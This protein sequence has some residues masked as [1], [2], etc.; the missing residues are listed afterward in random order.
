MRGTITIPAAVILLLAAA[1]VPSRAGAQVDPENPP[2]P[3][4]GQLAALEP[5]LGFYTHTDQ[6]F[7]GVGPFNGT[8]EVKP[9][10]K[11]WYVEWVIDTH[12][13]AIDRQNRMIMTW[14]EK[15]GRYRVWR[16][17]TLP[18]QP[19]G[20]VEGSARFVGDTLEMVWEGMPGPWGGTGTF[21]NRAFMDGPDELVIISDVLPE[22]ASERVRLTEWRSRRRM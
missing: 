10:V 3:P 19:P 21:R 1:A 7:A 11:G 18:Q 13:R 5:F 8:V 12:H 14:D 17:E 16:F 6:R 20:T 2:E 4:T 9:A 22:G 15:L